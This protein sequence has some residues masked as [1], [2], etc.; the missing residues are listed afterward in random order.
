MSDI[1][2][3][4]FGGRPDEVSGATAAAPPPSHSDLTVERLQPYLVKGSKAMG[5]KSGS[6]S[7]DPA[8]HEQREALASESYQ[9]LGERVA[10]ILTA[11]QEAAEDIR[12]IAQEDADRTRR[13]AHEQAAA[14]TEQAKQRLEGERHTLEELR[15]ELDR[16]SK[17]L[18]DDV[19][20]YRQQKRREAEAEAAAIRVAAEQAVK[21]VQGEALLLQR[22]LEGTIPR[23]HEVTS[24]LERVLASEPKVG[25]T[26]EHPADEAV[27]QEDY[28]KS[29]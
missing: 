2:R 9:H 1:V 25:E 13:E 5:N 27:S 28:A 24:W 20:A 17:E 19:D 10:A 23:F 8:Q 15:V 6:P 7:D 4:L 29:R 16:R 11:A 12:R 3:R 14:H 22:W 26:E 18:H 21:Q